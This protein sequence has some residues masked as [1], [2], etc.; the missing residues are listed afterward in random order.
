MAIQDKELHK[1]LIEK[2]LLDEKQFKSILSYAKKKKI[3]LEDALYDRS[4]LHEK[5]L[6]SIIANLYEV[7]YI[8]ITEQTIPEKLLP[9]VPHAM[10]SNQHVIPFKQEGNKLHLA[11]NNPHNFELINFLENK[12]GLEVVP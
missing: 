10:A 11:L 2:K 3:P 1:I 12:T 9:I 5:Q 8:D 6:A 4:L 7:P